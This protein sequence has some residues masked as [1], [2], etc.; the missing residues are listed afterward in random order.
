MTKLLTDLLEAGLIENLGGDDARLEKIAKASDTV[1]KELREQPPRLIRA[2]LAGIDPDI[3]PDDPAI[4]Q[5]KQA[6]VANWKSM[7]SVYADTPIGLLRA[8]LLEACSQVGG[9][10]REAA[11][12]WLTAAD[13]LPLQRLG[14]EERPIREMVRVWA[15]RTEEMA[16]V[17]SDHSEAQISS[18]LQ[19]LK[20]SAA[21]VTGSA[22][23]VD[24]QS[25]K[26]RVAAAA[27]Q[28]YRNQ[29]APE[30]ANPHYPNSPQAWSWEFADRMSVLL[31]DE[32][33]ALA[34][35]M[36]QERSQIGQALQ[37]PIS[38]LGTQ[39]DERLR[40]QD[41]LLRQNLEITERRLKMERIR[42]DALWWSEALYSPS[43]RRSYREMKATL[44]AV[45]MAMDLLEFVPRPAPAS[46]GFMLAETVNRLPTAGFDRQQ[47]IADILIGLH[48]LR[49]QL[50]NGCLS[51][52]GAPPAEGRMSLRDLVAQSLAFDEWNIGS[53]LER[54]GLAADVAFSLP[55]FAHA[56]FR[57]EQAVRLAGGSS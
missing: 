1:A 24:R 16:L 25:L 33:D 46:V 55:E 51:A 21:A 53:L 9:E 31:A 40:L 18:G 4:L 52:I 29:A 42:L 54:A 39:I 47:K 36:Q 35:D 57:Q 11:I 8:I 14:K 44:A 50:P 34:R 3:S 28:N 49:D 17:V 37:G 32:L 10:G 43:H 20:L 30:G 6:L 41:R 7:S 12:L 5:A 56:F 45:A 27:G 23:T 15:S 38:E 48:E 22:R 13:T 19:S 2:L 26:L